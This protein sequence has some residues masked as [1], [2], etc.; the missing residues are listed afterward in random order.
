MQ[1]KEI[2]TSF[3]KEHPRILH[4]MNG[5]DNGGIS[6]V[7]LNITSVI[8]DYGVI[9][10]CAM[11][12]IKLGVNGKALEKLGVNFYELP[13]KSKHPIQF[14]RE[15]IRI[16]KTNKYDVVHVHFNETSYFPLFIA[17]CIG[18]NKRIAHAH[19]SRKATNIIDFFR[20]ISSRVFTRHIVT[21]MVA[22]S[23]SAA[24]CMFG[25]DILNNKKLTILNNC[26]DT[27]L[28]MFD[29]QKRDSVRKKHGIDN[30]FVI[31]FVG[32]LEKEKNIPYA[33]SVF[34]EVLKRKEAYFLIIGSGSLENELRK[35][36]DEMCIADS[37]KF[38][39]QSNS[40]NE[41]LS[42]MDAF[43]MTSYY[44]GFAIA[45]L[46]ALASGLPVYLSDRI[47]NV[48]KFSPDA[49]YISIDNNPQEWAEMII[50][51]Y[52]EH[53]R[54]IKWKEV[55]NAGFDISHYKNRLRDLY[56]I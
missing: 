39:G 50:N 15:L 42:A 14:C 1:L 38:C 4:V 23:A 32:S 54:K 12:D 40:V 41:Y 17:K 21:N 13:L 25:R 16:L 27:K 45:A 34:N 55:F 49:H 10:D 20:Q 24:K 7:V 47:P 6:K 44:E 8:K 11:Y 33:L 31:G 28:Y 19:T 29:E 18:V 22:C 51:N 3:G 37:V 52:T 26:I 46:E 5:A 56:E 35:K 48:L 30:E 9:T 2:T 36:V 53:N 43:I